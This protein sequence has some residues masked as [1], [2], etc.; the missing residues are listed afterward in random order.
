MKRIALG[1]IVLLIVSLACNSLYSL[2]LSESDL[3]TSDDYVKKFGGDV[4]V[5]NRILSMNDCR[6]LNRE[7]NLALTKWLNQDR[8]SPE[9]K[10]THGYIEALSTR[11]IQ[12]NCAQ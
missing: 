7:Y 2:A 12:I 5:Y 3:K 10:I 8:L 9:R 11:M 6:A 1:I 4:D